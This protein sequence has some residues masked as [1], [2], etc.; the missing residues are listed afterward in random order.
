MD[1]AALARMLSVRKEGAA[2]SQGQA[3]RFDCDN[4]SNDRVDEHNLH[5]TLSCLHHTLGYYTT[6]QWKG[7]IKLHT[8]RQ[9][10]QQLS[11]CV[12]PSGA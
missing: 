10:G 6:R 11:G 5:F 12:D 2:A 7:E 8:A 9:L 1:D 4:T 3:P